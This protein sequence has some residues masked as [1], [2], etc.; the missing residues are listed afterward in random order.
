MQVA[1][2]YEALT[3]IS[4]P[5]TPSYDTIV[6]EGLPIHAINNMMT[7]LG[8]NKQE[9]AKVLDTSVRR[10]NQIAKTEEVKSLRPTGQ[11]VRGFKPKIPN[12]P[13]ALRA[14]L[15]KNST[16]R[17]LLVTHAFLKAVDYFE[18]EEKAREWFH[19]KNM[20]LGDKT[21]FEIC[22]TIMG[23]RRVENTIVKLEYG[24]TA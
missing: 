11:P 13:D 16:E 18:S 8:A 6:S 15:N 9:V 3:L 5:N 21:P 2:E 23:I 19:H 7:L 12:V 1:K 20:S 24:M 4:P 14:S 22:D 10:L 17:A